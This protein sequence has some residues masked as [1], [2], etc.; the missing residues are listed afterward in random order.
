A[1]LYVLYGIIRV[2]YTIIVSKFKIRNQ[3]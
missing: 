2:L 1:S 3:E